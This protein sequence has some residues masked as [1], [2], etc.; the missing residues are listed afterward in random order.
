MK[1]LL[2]LFLTLTLT[3]LTFIGCKQEEEKCE[4][5]NLSHYKFDLDNHYK[6]CLDCGEQVSLSAHSEFGDECTTCGF[7]NPAGS[8][9]L[10]Y[11]KIA[12]KDEYAVTG[13]EQNKV[14]SSVIIAS[15]YNGYPV[16]QVSGSAFTNISTIQ[17]IL[18]PYTINYI[19]PYA[20]SSCTALTSIKFVN[21]YGWRVVNSSTDMN[22]EELTPEEVSNSTA[23]AIKFR[24]SGNQGYG[25]KALRRFD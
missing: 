12:G 16:T 17:S 18:V 13:F 3:L 8:E 1:K 20:F 10:T 2:I 15:R 22:G 5:L 7:T 14:V 25:R 21:K 6:T 4:H 23:M 9:G 19:S 24:S 11:V